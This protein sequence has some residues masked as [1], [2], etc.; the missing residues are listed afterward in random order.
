MAIIFS[1]D[2]IARLV[3]S[4]TFEH[5]D[6]Y[7][8]INLEDEYYYFLKDITDLEEM[9]LFSL[10]VEDLLEGEYVIHLTP[11]NI[12][13]DVLACIAQSFERKYKPKNV[14]IN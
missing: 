12:N 4:V 10:Y 8:R 7:P 6:Y 5:L 9:V 3:A 11:V 1:E 13:V 2:I 14:Y